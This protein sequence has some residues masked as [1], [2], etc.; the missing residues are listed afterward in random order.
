M[1]PE[2]GDLKE[3]RVSAASPTAQP[4]RRA[5]PRGELPHEER[6]QMLRF[7]ALGEAGVVAELLGKLVG[8][9]RAAAGEDHLPA[10]ALRLDHVDELCQVP[11]MQVLLGD[12][13]RHEDRVRADLDCP[14]EQ[15]KLLV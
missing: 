12:G 9:A 3:K 6:R 4:A 1:A 7:G 11:H 8:H 2:R 10:P 13:L 5:H 14:G 15:P